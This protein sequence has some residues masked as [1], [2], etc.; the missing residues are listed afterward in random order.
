MSPRQ[1]KTNSEISE[2]E[3]SI[4]ESLNFLEEAVRSLEESP[5]SLEEAFALYEKA[6][7]VAVKT[8]DKIDEVEKKVMV[9]KE[10]GAREEFQ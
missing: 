2:N 3:L 10:N 1:K 4:E 8:H 9:I 7:K 5:L 6:M